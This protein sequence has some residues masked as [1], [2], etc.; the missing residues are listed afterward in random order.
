[1][2]IVITIRLYSSLMKLNVKKGLIK[3]QKKII[4]F[5]LELCFDRIFSFIHDLFV[6]GAYEYQQKQF[7]LCVLIFFFCSFV[8]TL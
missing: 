3:R 2:E 8:D 5:C 4:Q 7:R 6:A 1:M